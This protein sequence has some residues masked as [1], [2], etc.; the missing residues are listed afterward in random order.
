MAFNETI[1]QERLKELFKYSSETG[2]FTRI[3]RTGRFLPGTKVGCEDRHGYLNVSIDNIKYKLHRLAWFYYYG[4]WPINM[5]DHINHI[6]DD[7]RIC[8]LRVVDCQE[9]QRNEK[10]STN[11]TS[12]VTG[13]WYRKDRGMWVAEIK[14]NYKKINL[15]HFKNKEDAIKARKQAEKEYNFHP[16]HGAPSN[17]KSHDKI[18]K[19]AVVLKVKE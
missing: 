17:C 4:E 9:N 8:N 13:V 7:N 19:E 11:N 2:E 16:N 3:Q 10:I 1:T 18:K 6:P 14:V 15:G 5:L 12:G